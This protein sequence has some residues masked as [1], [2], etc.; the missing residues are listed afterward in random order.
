E[1]QRLLTG[2]GADVEDAAPRR[3]LSHGGGPPPHAPYHHGEEIVDGRETAE[4]LID[5]LPV[6]P[7]CPPCL[8]HSPRPL[9][10]RNSVQRP[11]PCHT[12]RP[13]ATARDRPPPGRARP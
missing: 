6:F 11:G 7:L 5:H 2:S 13:A 8:G 3:H 12:R 9:S 4:F 10:P 1:G